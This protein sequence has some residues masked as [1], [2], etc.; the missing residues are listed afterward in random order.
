M[1]RG[2]AVGLRLGKIIHTA[3]L[4]VDPLWLISEIAKELYRHIDPWHQQNEPDTEEEAATEEISV[5]ENEEK[6]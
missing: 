1:R 2:A 5:I 4:A 3:S 6:S